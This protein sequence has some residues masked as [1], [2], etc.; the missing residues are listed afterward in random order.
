MKCRP[1]ISIHITSNMFSAHE[2]WK[3]ATKAQKRRL[4]KWMVFHAFM[5]YVSLIH[6][7]Q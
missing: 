7:V 3:E 5:G 6:Y 1:D 4:G 2:R